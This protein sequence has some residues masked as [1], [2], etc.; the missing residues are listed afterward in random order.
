MCCCKYNYTRCP[1]RTVALS[2]T[3]M[4]GIDSKTGETLMEGRKNYFTANVTELLLRPFIW[5]CSVALPG[6]VPAG[7]VAF[8]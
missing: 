7:T 5:I 2:T 3:I 1:R 4:C 6:E 8:T